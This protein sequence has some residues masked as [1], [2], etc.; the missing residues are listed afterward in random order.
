M[1]VPSYQTQVPYRAALARPVGI[2]R[3]TAESSRSKYWADVATAGE[4][5]GSAMQLKDAMSKFFEKDTKHNLGISE[6]EPT[7]L[8]EKS[9]SEDKQARSFFSAEQRQA[10]LN[11]SRQE[12]FAEKLSEERA[13]TPL[14]RLDNYFTGEIGKLNAAEPVADSLLAQDYVVLRHEVNALEQKQARAKSK[15]QFARGAGNFVQIAGMIS[16]P[17]ALEHY[18]DSNLSA[19][20]EEA[21]QQGLSEQTWQRQKQFLQTEAVQ[22]NVQSALSAGEVSQA[23][24][25]YKH[26]SSQLPSQTREQL[27]EKITSCLAEKLV[28][29]NPSLVQAITKAAEDP[30]DMEK[31]STLV[32]QV[33]TECGIKSQLL[34]T[35]VQTRLTQQ[36]QEAHKRRASF[37]E[38]LLHTPNGEQTLQQTLLTQTC[39]TTDE[40]LRVQQICQKWQ[41]HPEAKS[42]PQI[43]NHLYGQICLGQDVQEN[44]TKSLA[45]NEI[46][47]RDWVCL[48][49]AVHHFLSA[50]T[51]PR[52]EIL[53]MALDKWCRSA[54]LTPAE[55]EQAHYFV[56][57]AG[58]GFDARL[59]AAQELKNLL[60]LQEK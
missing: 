3:P 31:C 34:Q 44:L 37:Y 36:M 57:S 58:T 45:H 16:S 49:Q 5:A 33:A 27:E 18:I 17:T 30:L 26:F 9:S 48:Q 35:A 10:L 53:K 41:S 32:E 28:Q 24:A 25:V 14:E 47:P 51:D 42:N 20:Q 1:K 59:L 2:A 23:Q 7:S 22:H 52:E 12:V 19:A 43:F 15:E 40:F 50:P 39:L 56:Y 46:C 11:F 29:E 4:I 60:T 8:Q 38:Q 21:A 6:N 54:A 13:E 55:Q